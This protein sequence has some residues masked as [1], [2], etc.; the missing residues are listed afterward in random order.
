MAFKSLIKESYGPKPKGSNL[1]LLNEFN[2][3]Y[4]KKYKKLGCG[5]KIEDVNLSQI[6]NYMKVDMITNIENNI[7]MNFIS[8]L[9]RFVNASFKSLRKLIYDTTEEYPKN[10]KK[11]L[12]Y[13]IKQDLINNT[14]NTKSIHHKW[15][16][17]NGF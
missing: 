6:L 3:F 16:L 15:I 13:D 14:L 2:K 12:R 11:I 9:K 1:E 4:E 5:D 17:K 8:Y 10:I 7:K